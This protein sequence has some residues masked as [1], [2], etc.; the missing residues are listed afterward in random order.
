MLWKSDLNVDLMS[1]S[2]NHIDIRVNDEVENLEW[3]YTE[4]YGNPE[5]ANKSLSWDLMDT[6]GGLSNLPW[7]CGGDFNEILLD[8]EKKGGVVRKSS[9]MQNFRDVV[10]KCNLENLG[11]TGYPFTWSNGREG[12]ENIRRSMNSGWV[13]H[14]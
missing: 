3:R 1:L 12:Y 5:E 14:G 13:S 10:T 2:L 9:S 8:S 11:F 7:L 6:L 4:F